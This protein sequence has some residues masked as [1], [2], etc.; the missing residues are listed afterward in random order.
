[1]KGLTP[2]DFAGY[3]GYK[4]DLY[5]GG[6]TL[7]NGIAQPAATVGVATVLSTEGR[8][9]RR[10]KSREEM[11]ERRRNTNGGRERKY[12]KEINGGM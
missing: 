6:V 5:R 3:G 7:S 1:M 2:R 10:Q 12:S 9:G 11:E 8:R 4:H